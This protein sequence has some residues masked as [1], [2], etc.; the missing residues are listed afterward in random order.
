MTARTLIGTVLLGIALGLPGVANGG[1][2]SSWSDEHQRFE[3]GEA[4]VRY[5]ADAGATERR[6]AREGGRRGLRA[7][8]SSCRTPRW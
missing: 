8:R 2:V 3:P 4:L 6:E 1:V 5:A 7:T